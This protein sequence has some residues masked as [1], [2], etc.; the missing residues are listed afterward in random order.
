M[1]TTKTDAFDAMLGHHRLLEEHV[2]SRVG[3]V[4]RAVADNNSCEAAVAELVACLAD[5]V[6]P[7][8]LAEEHTIYPVAALRGDLSEVVAGM[9]VEHRAL[10]SATERL[11]DAASRDQAGSLAQEI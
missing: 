10:A 5:E 9:V 8:A 11:A 6:L 1:T 3:A 7:H 2:E 4:M